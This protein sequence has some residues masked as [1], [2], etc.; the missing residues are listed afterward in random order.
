MRTIAVANQKGG[1]GKTTTAIN[2]SACLASKGRRVL[3]IDMDPQGHCG[4]GLNV[5][6]DLIQKTIYDALRESGN[7]GPNLGEIAIAMNETFH[8]IPANI[9]LSKFEQEMA[10]SPGREMRLKRVVDRLWGLQDYVIIDCPPSLGLLTFNS[11]IA[12]AEVI[13]P[14]EMGLFALHGTAR[15]LEIIDLVRVKTGHRIGAKVLPTMVDKRTRIAREVLEE[16]ESHFQGAMYR[17]RIHANVHLREAAG[18][19]RPVC[20]FAPQSQGAADY[21]ALAEEVLEEEER[22]AASA[23]G[24]E[25]KFTFHAPGARTVRIV[26]TFNDWTPDDASLMEKLEEGLWTKIVRLPPGEHQYKFIVDDRWVE[27][28]ANPRVVEDPYGGRNSVI[29]VN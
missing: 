1:C 2:L 12:A 29:N 4:M 21:L 19:G 8:L 18:H 7:G 25:R 11:L 28:E 3:L 10:M 16:I 20:D 22:L 9:H 24:T 6:I 14:I 13:I 17:T 27:D 26:G 15:L 5:V 23:A